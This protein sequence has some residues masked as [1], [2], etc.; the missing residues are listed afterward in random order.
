[1]SIDAFNEASTY[2]EVLNWASSFL[3]KNNKQP[4]IAQWIMR[5]R[6]NL[7]L[8]ELMN[9]SRSTMS[10]DKKSQY[11][12]DLKKAVE[13][14]PPQH[15]VGHEWFYNRKF[16]VTKDTLIPR[17]ETEEW[18]HRYIKMLP[19]KSL[20]VL[21]LGTGTGV[22]AISHKLE[23]PQ[24]QVTAVDI[25]ESA[26]EIASENAKTLNAEVCFIKSNMTAEVS[27]KFDLILS[28]PPY[29]GENELKDMDES[30]WKFEPHQALFA[31]E[32]GLH[33]YRILA[34]ATPSFLNPGG[35]MI[36]ECGFKQGET[37]RALFETYFP[38]AA[39]EIWKDFNALDRALYLK[40]NE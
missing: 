4:H 3:E 28:N 6:F 18:F 37:I 20:S 29:I 27:G 17:P 13:G 8:T 9:R 10:A 33:F 38:K 5:E 16:T 34:E 14:Y 19:E 35:Q 12:E 15:I 31:E 7:T 23:R 2:M 11:I 30:V 32:E 21:D 40:A 1:M 26:L 24:D 25:S 22:L 36:F 39:V